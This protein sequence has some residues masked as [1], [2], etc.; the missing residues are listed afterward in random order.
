MAMSDET[1]SVKHAIWLKQSCLEDFTGFGVPR[2]P[3][4]LPLPF[5]SSLLPLPLARSDTGDPPASSYAIMRR[6]SPYR[7]EN[8]GPGRM[9][10]ESLTPKPGIRAHNRGQSGPQPARLRAHNKPSGQD[11]PNRREPRVL[12][13]RAPDA[14]RCGPVCGPAPTPY[15]HTPP[16]AGARR[17]AASPMTLVDAQSSRYDCCAHTTLQSL[18]SRRN[19][20]P[21]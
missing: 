17:H 14:A 2:Y 20:F 18:V 8:S 7:G 1:N 19:H 9:I 15:S 5:A 4:T 16:H 3:P 10:A 12:P 13:R 6:A 21:F 11:D